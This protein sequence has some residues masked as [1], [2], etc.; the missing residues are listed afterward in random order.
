MTIKRMSDSLI[1]DQDRVAT[2]YICCHFCNHTVLTVPLTFDE[3]TF[4]T[5]A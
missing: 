5:V 4:C 1:V 2:G 3:P